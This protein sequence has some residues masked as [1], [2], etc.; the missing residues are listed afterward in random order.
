MWVG[1]FALVLSSQETL[2][3]LVQGP[4][5]ANHCTMSYFLLSNPC[6]LDRRGHQDS[7][8]TREKSEKT[9]PDPSGL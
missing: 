6:S 2:M 9:L 4:H 8:S 3:L 7:K 1:E 5:F